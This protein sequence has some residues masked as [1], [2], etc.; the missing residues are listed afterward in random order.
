[1][2]YD[3]RLFCFGS[4]DGSVGIVTGYGLDG[5]GSILAGTTF[6]PLHSVQTGSGAHPASYPMDAGG[7]TSEYKAAGE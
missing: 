7:F 1:V 6:S 2:K 4:R 5:R 3:N